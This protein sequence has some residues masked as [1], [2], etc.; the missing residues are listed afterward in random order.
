MLKLTLA[1]FVLTILSSSTANA[2]FWGVSINGSPY[3]HPDGEHTTLRFIAHFSDSQDRIQAVGSSLEGEPVW[4]RSGRSEFYN[5]PVY[6]GFWLN[7]FPSYPIGGELWDTYVT[8]GASQW[9]SNV[10]FTP[11]FLDDSKD[12]PV[13]SVVTECNKEETDGNWYYIGNPPQVSSLED[14]IEGNGSYDV[15]IAQF[16]VDD[17]DSVW[18][19]GYMHWITPEG[20]PMVEYFNAG[21]LASPPPADINADYCVN[22]EDLLLLLAAWGQV[23]HDSGPQ[24]CPWPPDYNDDGEV[25]VFDLLFLLENWCTCEDC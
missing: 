4:F 10:A 16:T 6:A 21:N 14:A 1:I 25:G 9:P 13:I 23:D 12:P 22:T 7:D 17:G 18:M 20:K 15:L 3:Q 19:G 24:I 5:Q 11:G 8:I 2:D